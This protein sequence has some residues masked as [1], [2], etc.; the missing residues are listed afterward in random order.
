[1]VC[2]IKT[3]HS[4]RESFPKKTRILLLKALVISHLHYPL[5]LL[6]ET[7]KKLTQLAKIDLIGQKRLL[8]EK[9]DHISDFKD[10][11]EK[12]SIFSEVHIGWWVQLRNGILP[13]VANENQQ[14][15]LSKIR[16]ERTNCIVLEPCTGIL[17]GII[18]HSF[19]DKVVQL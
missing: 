14:Q 3:L 10:F 17:R 12:Y 6:N 19:S 16:S 4:V 11:T 8:Q 2:A 1:M 7:T 15:P 18:K 9:I 13:A 5:V